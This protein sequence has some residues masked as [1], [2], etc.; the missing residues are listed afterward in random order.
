MGFW[1]CRGAG[2]QEAYRRAAAAEQGMG[3]D[4]QTSRVEVQPGNGGQTHRWQGSQSSRW[5]AKRVISY[6]VRAPKEMLNEGCGSNR[7]RAGDVG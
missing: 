4:Q 7:R 6:H 2:C 5:K 3:G 1:P